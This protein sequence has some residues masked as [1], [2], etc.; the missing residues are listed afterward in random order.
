[1]WL[2]LPLR[3]KRDARSQI[4]DDREKPRRYFGSSAAMQNYDGMFIFC[5]LPCSLA[6]ANYANAINLNPI[7]SRPAD[8][9]MR[10][11]SMVESSDFSPFLWHDNA[12][13]GLRLEMGEP[14]RGD[15]TANLVLD[16]DHIVEWICQP[17]TAPTLRVAP[18]LLR[19][20]NAGDLQIGIDCG[21]SRGQVAL[22]ELSIDRITREPI[23]GRALYRWAVRLNFPAGGFIHFA[24][25]SYELRQMKEPVISSTSRLPS[26]A[27]GA[28]SP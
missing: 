25:A 4:P 9:G 20:F 7:R 10:K 13:H 12:L 14:E 24:A 19:F 21:D 23:A 3:G 5:K 1:L 6:S 16:I 27:R 28:D 17:G 18:A 2:A 15:W 22:H 26:G 11:S 8:D